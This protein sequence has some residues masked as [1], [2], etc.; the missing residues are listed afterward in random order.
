M[1]R[2]L[3][4][5]LMV[6]GFSGVAVL[7]LVGLLHAPI[8]RTLAQSSDASTVPIRSLT[9]QGSTGNLLL[10]PDFEDGYYLYPGHNSIRV[11]NG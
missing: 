11:P 5:I 8:D 1:M 9:N 2:R 4:S 10:N 7:I 3:R 6:A